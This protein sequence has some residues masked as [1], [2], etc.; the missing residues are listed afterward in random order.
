MP[1]AATMFSAACRNMAS[2]PSVS[3]SAGAATMLSPVWTPTGSMFSMEQTET[4]QPLASRIVSNSI[5]FQPEMHFSTRICVMGDM[6]RP[7][8]AM[9]RSSSGVSAM[10]PPVPPSVKAGRTMIGY[11]ISSAISSAVSTSLAMADGTQ[12][13]PMAAIVSRNSSRSSALSMPPMSVP[14]SRTPRRS[15]V[16]SRLSCMAIVRPVCPP[17]PASSP[18]GFSFSRMRRTVSA[19]SGSR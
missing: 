2:S 11:P 14:S 7:D 12:G 19:F 8:A 4:A 13:W 5:S 15:S 1:M 18:S 17:R 6:S 3:V 9:M 16:P 10:P